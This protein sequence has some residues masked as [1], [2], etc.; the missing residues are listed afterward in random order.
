MISHSVAHP[1]SSIVQQSTKS[2]SV[3][4]SANNAVQQSKMKSPSASQPVP[5]TSINF[6]FLGVAYE[7]VRVH[8]SSGVNRLPCSLFRAMLTHCGAAVRVSLSLVTI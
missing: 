5:I 3:G 6:Q 8:N 4:H 2:H 7:P 1:A